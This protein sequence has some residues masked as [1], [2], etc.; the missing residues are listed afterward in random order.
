M[1]VHFIFRVIDLILGTF[2]L[3]SAPYLLK[4]VFVSF[5][6][7]ERAIKR[8]VQVFSILGLFCLSLSLL[9][10]VGQFIWKLT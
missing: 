8:M 5:L 7:E 6:D 10:I 3:L 4:M 1:E 9:F 2:A